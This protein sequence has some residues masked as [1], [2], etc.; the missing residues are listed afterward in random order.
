MLEVKHQLG[1]RLRSVYSTYTSVRNQALGFFRTRIFF[2]ERCQ[3]IELEPMERHG[4]PGLIRRVRYLQNF[5]RINAINVI[6]I[7]SSG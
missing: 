1:L 7:R 6:V 2:Q 5:I 4:V 3:N